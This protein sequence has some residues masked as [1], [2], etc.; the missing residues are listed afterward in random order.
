LRAAL[1]KQLHHL[2]VLRL[3]SIAGLTAQDSGVA[4]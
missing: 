4:L 3:R 2:R 1:K